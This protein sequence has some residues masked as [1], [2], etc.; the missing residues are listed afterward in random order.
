MEL[1]AAAAAAGTPPTGS[2]RQHGSPGQHA[3]GRAAAGLGLGDDDED[4]EEERDQL[5]Y[6]TADVQRGP[7]PSG[8][9]VAAVERALR[10]SIEQVGRAFQDALAASLASNLAAAGGP[11]LPPAHGGAGHPGSRRAASAGRL[12]GPASAGAAVPSGI[13]GLWGSGV[14]VG[15]TGA[16]G[17]A[18]FGG[19]PPAF[20][21]HGQRSAYD[22]RGG[23]G[24]ADASILGLSESLFSNAAAAGGPRGHSSS[25]PHVSRGRNGGHSHD[26]GFGGRGGDGFHGHHPMV[27]GISDGDPYYSGAENMR[28][29]AGLGVH[30]FDGY[31]QSSGPLTAGGAADEL[32]LLQHPHQHQ[33]H[34]HASAQPPYHSLS[35][36]NKWRDE[37]DM[38]SSLFDQHSSWLRSFKQQV[39]CVSFCC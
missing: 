20:P 9:P 30:G 13:G 2:R 12:R 1:A 37:R 15:P 5:P 29:G 7:A 23:R 34:H 22:L 24:G 35:F 17:G 6:G 8:D 26:L 19:A 38:A 3:A 21:V 32:G 28:G 18:S 16:A 27:G 25:R 14:R 31:S 11:P 36:L 39:G 10:S 33:H 4:E